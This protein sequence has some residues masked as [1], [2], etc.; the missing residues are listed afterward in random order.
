[1]LSKVVSVSCQ[2]NWLISLDVKKKI[3]IYH[4]IN[5]FTLF[6][7][8]AAKTKPSV[9]DSGEHK[10]ELTYRDCKVFHNL[11]YEKA[12]S[13]QERPLYVLVALSILGAWFVV[14]TQ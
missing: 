2:S 8:A 4:L 1:M 12:D 10:R 3:I 11:P 7:N 6:Y 14:G 5:I 13:I 9:H